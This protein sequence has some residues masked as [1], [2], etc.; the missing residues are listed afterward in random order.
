MYIYM[1]E[2]YKKVEN[3][4]KK[5]DKA[6]SHKTVRIIRIPLYINLIRVRPVFYFITF[7]AIQSPQEEA[8]AAQLVLNNG[9]SVTKLNGKDYF[10]HEGQ[11]SEFIYGKT[12]WKYYFKP[13]ILNHFLVS[14]GSTLIQPEKNTTLVNLNWLLESVLQVG[15]KVFNSKDNFS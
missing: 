2:V 5:Q 1:M 6:F 13:P 9:A 8:V 10:R 11:N 7:L 3:I 12:F 14:D 4:A 15:V